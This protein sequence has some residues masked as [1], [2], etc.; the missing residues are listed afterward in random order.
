MTLGMAISCESAYS[1]LM[2]VYNAA[3]QEY[4]PNRLVTPTIIRPI[5]NAHA[6]DGTWPIPTAN[7]SLANMHWYVNGV[8]ISLLDD[9]VNLYLSD[10]WWTSDLE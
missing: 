5:V 10:T 6:A 3:S 1:P 7:G 2:Q 9:W 4:E 8:D